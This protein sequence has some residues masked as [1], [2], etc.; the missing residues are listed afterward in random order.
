[1]KTKLP[2]KW[3]IPESLQNRFGTKGIG[4]Q[5]AMSADGHLLLILHKLNES[6]E[7][8]AVI[9]WRNSKGEWLD[10]Q[11]GRGI[12]KLRSLIEDYMSKEL[13][14]SELYEKASTPE[15]YFDLLEILAPLVRV[16]KNMATTLQQA[17][18]LQGGPDIIDLRDMTQELAQDLDILYEDA[19][20]GLDYTVAKRTEEQA[21][22]ALKTSKSTDK[23]NILV[24]VF[25]PITALSGIFGMNMRNGLEEMPSL[26]F[27]LMMVMS[28]V[29][30]LGVKSWIMA[31]EKESNSA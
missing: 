1:M 8:E 9:F 5:R 18:E 10:S 12:F 28:F 24:A 20:N 29:I 26:A 19:K 15:N 27:W 16:S 22:Y 30:G 23:L 7:T 31:E 21:R 3:N 6:L 25:L 4:K 11:K 2:E 14:L 13:Q 17:R